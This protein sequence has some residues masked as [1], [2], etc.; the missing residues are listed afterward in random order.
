[1]IEEERRRLAALTKK[2]G[3]G[4]RKCRELEDFQVKVSE[5]LHRFMEAGKTAEQKEVL[6]SLCA[7]MLG[8]EGKRGRTAQGDGGAGL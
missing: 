6:A 5:I 1:M 2:E 3:S 7:G 4:G 8:R